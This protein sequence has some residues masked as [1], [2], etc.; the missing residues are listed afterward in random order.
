MST[1]FE[2]RLWSQLEAAAAREARRGPVAQALDHARA[3]LRA[4][5][6]PAAALAGIVAALAVG[7]LSGVLQHTP[8]QHRPAQMAEL[9]H[10]AGRPAD[11]VS[12]AGAVWLF[13][14]RADALLRVD[15]ADG[16]VLARTP[17]RSGA[18][19]AALAAAGGSVW[20]VPT[21][22]RS[23]T[24]PDRIG[25]PLP[26]IHVDTRSGLAGQSDL[27]TPSGTPFVPFG[28]VATGDALWVWG[29]TGALRI[30][31]ASGRVLR[32]I[33]VRHDTVMGFT[34]TADT[35]WLATEDGRLL[36]V[37]A[38][39]GARTGAWPSPPIGGPVDVVAAGNVVAVGGHTGAVT[40]V[41][42]T[43]GQRRWRTELGAAR[44][45]AMLDGRL[46]LAVPSPTRPRDD[47]L[48]VD[49]A[50]GRVVSRSPLPASGAQAVVPVGDALWVVMHDGAV[51]VVR[52]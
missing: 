14:D 24:A 7:A 32:S 20:I 6:A 25:R 47:L 1:G 49:P 36:R 39:T 10:I 19:A 5:L 50:T 43:T 22:W 23:H 12:A 42:A 40:G 21:P 41:D 28:L 9:R 27:R 16:R 48:A 52:P 4:S 11:G 29:P 13:D 17:L 3:G 45:I 37:D 30:D 18:T 34:A 26:L 2:D 46:W 44:S 31:P 15:P 38:R 33:T 35:A 8:P 51:A